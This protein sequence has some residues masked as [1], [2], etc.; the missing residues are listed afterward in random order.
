[1]IHVMLDADD[2][3]YIKDCIEDRVENMTL[4]HNELYGDFALEIEQGRR[5]LAGLK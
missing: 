2:L 4:L 1:M 3:A 5:L